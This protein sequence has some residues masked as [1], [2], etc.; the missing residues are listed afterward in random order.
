MPVLLAHNF[1]GLVRHY[2]LRREANQ[3]DI[4]VNLRSVEERSRQS[5]DLAKE[6][7]GPIQEIGKK[8]NA[9][10]KVAEVPPG[11]P[12]VSTLVAEVYGPDYKRQ[13]EVARQ[14][15]DIFDR[16]PGVVDADWYVV[17]DQRET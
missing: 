11:P 10:I 15:R 17:A 3:G 7:R 16:T 8:W 14:I 6:M 9:R 2:Y 1:N 5:H 4:Q 12:V 13:I